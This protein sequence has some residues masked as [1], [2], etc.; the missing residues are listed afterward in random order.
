MAGMQWLGEMP[1]R[2]N[3]ASQ[4]GAAIE[5]GTSA[6]FAA[7]EKKQA[8]AYKKAALDMAQKE[9]GIKEKTLELETKKMAFD[10]MMKA[11][12]TAIEVDSKES[13]ET[14]AL[15]SR[16]IYEQFGVDMEGHLTKSRLDA[17]NRE[18]ALGTVIKNKNMMRMGGQDRVIQ[19]A[20]RVALR[21]GGMTREQMADLVMGE[22]S[23]PSMDEGELAKLRVRVED[24]MDKQ[25]SFAYRAGEPIGA[26]LGAVGKGMTD[27]ARGARDLFTK[28]SVNLRVPGIEPPPV[29][30]TEQYPSLFP[31]TPA[32]QEWRKERGKKAKEGM[33][34]FFS[35]VSEGAR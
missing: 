19:S 4:V 23:L 7:K 18:K 9:L 12:Q 1:R 32:G 26:G 27:L 2:P 22:A 33:G 11:F 16:S 30:L 3:A 15:L 28:G 25:E 14:A 24:E 20:T 35:G 17:E 6:Y 34:R 13:R 5:G 10:G 31:H 21:R 29:E 8:D